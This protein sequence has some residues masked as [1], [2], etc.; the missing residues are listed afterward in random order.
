MP[1]CE[2]P[3]AMR[4]R[5]RPRGTQSDLPILSERKDVLLL[6]FGPLGIAL[7]IGFEHISKM[8]ENFGFGTELGK[9]MNAFYRLQT[10]ERYVS[11]KEMGEGHV[12]ETRDGEEGVG[13][14]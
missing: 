8:R 3:S 6:T 13:A 10:E 4:L 12:T 5:V 14:G 11:N 2:I 1:N 9:H 7:S